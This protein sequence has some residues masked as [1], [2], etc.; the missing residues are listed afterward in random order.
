MGLVSLTFIVPAKDTRFRTRMV[1]SPHKWPESHQQKR[2]ARVVALGTELL[3]RSLLYRRCHDCEG[4][5]QTEFTVSAQGMS[6]YHS[7][8][9]S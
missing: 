9:T 8:D 5:P 3:P 1:R 2:H 7:T 4:G 6:N